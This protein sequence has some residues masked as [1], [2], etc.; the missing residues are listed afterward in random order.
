VKTKLATVQNLISILKSTRVD[1]DGGNYTAEELL[2]RPEM[3]MNLLFALFPAISGNGDF[4]GEVKRLVEIQVKYEGYINRHLQEVERFRRME[5]RFLPANV[6][7][8]EIKS[9]SYEGREQLKRIQPPSLGAASRIYGV[10]PADIAVLAVYLRKYN[11]PCG[12]VAEPQ[13]KC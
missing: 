3:N 9:L 7:Y 2:K 12:T 13:R 11:V 4:N 1:Y 8:D 10:T 6:A 5:S